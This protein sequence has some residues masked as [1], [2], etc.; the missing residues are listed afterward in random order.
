M[1]AKKYI[2]SLDN[3][4]LTPKEVSTV[5]AH[6]RSCKDASEPVV[7]SFL[8]KIE[9]TRRIKEGIDIGLSAATKKKLQAEKAK[10]KKPKK[11][12]FPLPLHLRKSKGLGNLPEVFQ[13]ELHDDYDEH[14][15]PAKVMS[16]A[17]A[18]K[19]NP[20]TLDLS[21]P[22]AATIGE[23]TEV[24][25]LMIHGK[26]GSGKTTYMLLLADEL[27]RLGKTLYITAEQFN[28]GSFGQALNRLVDEK[29]IVNRSFDIADTYRGLDLSRYK[30]VIVD[31]KDHLDTTIREFKDL[32]KKY[33]KTSLLVISQSTKDGNYRGETK[34]PHEVDTLLLA[35]DGII[36]TGSKNRFNHRGSYNVFE[37]QVLDKWIAL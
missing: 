16:F 29:R 25:S 8:E 21:E 1:S 9:K 36:S 13:P 33:P 7:M 5:I 32:M 28:T 15:G 31:S 34:W 14:E 27:S 22:F 12:H 6:I 2:L 4:V 37:G 17:E 23:P 30:F 19:V 10:P 24:F 35:K 20:P 3:K 11:T 26:P 18:V